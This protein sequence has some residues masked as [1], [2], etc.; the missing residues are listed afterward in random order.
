MPVTKNRK[1]LF[2]DDVKDA[3]D[4]YKTFFEAISYTVW[5]ATDCDE[6]LKVVGQVSPDLLVIEYRLSGLGG[7]G[8][9]K[10]VREQKRPIKIMLTT[11][12]RRED[13]ENEFRGLGVAQIFEKPLSLKEFQEE[14]ENVLKTEPIKKREER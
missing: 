9:V 6:A 2:V 5:T 8:V 14:I 13:I 12:G 10:K 4:T 7:L 11:T 1:I 3:L